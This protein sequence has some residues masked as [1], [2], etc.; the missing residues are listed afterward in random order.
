MIPLFLEQK[1][2]SELDPGEV[3]RYKDMPIKKFFTPS[4]TAAFLFGIPW[5]A[6]AL[7]WT[8]GASGFEIPDFNEGFDIFPLF[9]IPFILVGI[10][11]LSTPLWSYWKAGKSVYVITN[12]R[13]I[14]FEGGK[15]TTIRSYPP[16][17][18]SD[19]Y[20][21]EKRDGTGDVIIRVKAWKD[22]EGDRHS[23]ELGFLRIRDPKSVEQMLKKLVE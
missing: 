10:G 12:R 18:L 21:K 7:F 2:D 15:E 23:E 14:T 1:I 5:T 6:F 9:G 13:A 19:I 4:S 20:R 22:S 17:K 8:A 11:M 3:V 16:N